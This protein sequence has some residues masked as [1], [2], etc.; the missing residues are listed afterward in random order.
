MS[1]NSATGAVLVATNATPGAYT[2]IYSYSPRTNCDKQDTAV[3]TVLT[4][5]DI[6]NTPI[7][8]CDSAQVN[9]TWYY[10]SQT[11][12]DNF[13]NQSGCDSVE[14]TVVKRSMYH[15]K[16]KPYLLNWTRVCVTDTA[17]ALSGGAPLGGVYSGL[18][19][20][21]AT[22][23]FDAAYA[24][25]GK[26]LFV[27]TYVDLI[28]GCSDTAQDSIVVENCYI[29]Y[30]SYT[31]GFWGS[32]NGKANTCDSTNGLTTLEIIKLIL[33]DTSVV[34]GDPAASCS[35]KWRSF[36]MYEK[37][38]L[39]I[40]AV[41]PAGGPS[42]VLDPVRGRCNG[43]NWTTMYN[44]VFTSASGGAMSPAIK[45]KKN[46]PNIANTLVGQAMALSLN[47]LYDTTLS[48]LVIA[49]DT[50]H[51]EKSLDCDSGRFTPAGSPQTDVLPA[52]L[53][54]YFGGGLHGSATTCACQ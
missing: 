51:T 53:R 11:V 12:V 45:T 50:I 31:Q 16:S 54:T 24:G 28:T 14:T 42:K 32:A 15:P 4:R 5:D 46:K 20:D 17:F 21:T 39:N 10:T 26:H 35:D 30:C 48:S 18:V 40:L 13:T 36:T 9:G 3:F 41:L 44:T 47:T 1:I 2:V 19:V 23:L 33:K 34:I 7:R 8:A 37:D 27:Y 6:T 25:L 43:S 22:G 38:S 29:P 52:S 49:G